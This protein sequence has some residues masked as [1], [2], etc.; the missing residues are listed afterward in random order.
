MSRLV[1]LIIV[2]LLLIGALYFLSTLPKQ[3]PT[4]T[5]AVDVPQPGTLGGNAH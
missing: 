3:G 2:A 1:V 4:H 5:I